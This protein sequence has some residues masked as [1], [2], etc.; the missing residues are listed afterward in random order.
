MTTPVFNIFTIVLNGMPWIERHIE[1][2]RQ[3]DMPWRWTIV[4]G[5]A[6]PVADTKW[7]Q[8]VPAGEDVKD[9]GTLAYLKK[10][11]GD[12]RFNSNVTVITRERWPGKTAMCN[13]ALETFTAPGSL[14]QVDADEF[15]TLNQLRVLPTLWQMWP[16][17]T[18]ARFNARV[19]V[20]PR[21]F[22]CVPGQWAN[23]DYE[24]DR[25]WRFTPGMS[26]ASHEPPR[27][28]GT[29]RIVGRDATA[30]FGL[31]FD[32][33]SYVLRSQIEWKERYYSPKWSVEAWDR[34]Q[35]M[36]GMVDLQTVL[37]FVDSPTLSFET[38]A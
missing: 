31:V 25:F 36:R 13:A 24:W 37:P 38:P 27:F 3:L 28:E 23:R 20:G 19:W 8:G 22:C 26:F 1:T 4:H 17:A 11:Q 10:L 35:N 32:H 15:W 2:F 16:E 9:D 21:R 6:D 14:L 29:Q 18:A 30:A 12:W 5:V 34:L 33:Y 7:V